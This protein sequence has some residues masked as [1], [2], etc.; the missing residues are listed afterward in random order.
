M[1]WLLRAFK[2]AGEKLNRIT[3]YKVWR[4]GNQPKLL[5]SYSFLKQNLDYL[6]NNPVDSEI[7][8]EPH[9]YKYSSARDYIGRLRVI[10]RF[11][12]FWVNV[13]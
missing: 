13:G 7:V 5:M 12:V 10:Y 6:H 9:H 3:K 2:K 8:D 1:G 11:Y 4:D